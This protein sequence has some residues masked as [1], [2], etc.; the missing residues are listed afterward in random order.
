MKCLIRS[1][2]CIILG[3]NT[4]G[5]T[6]DDRDSNDGDLDSTHENDDLR[7]S[8]HDE[9][10]DAFKFLPAEISDFESN[11]ESDASESA[12]PTTFCKFTQHSFIRETKRP[13]FTHHN[14]VGWL[15]SSQLDSLTFAPN[16]Q[17]LDS[18]GFGSGIYVRSSE[19]AS[20]N[21]SVSQTD[22]SN[23]TLQSTKSSN[24]DNN[25]APTTRPSSKSEE[26]TEVKRTLNQTVLHPKLLMAARS[27]EIHREEYIRKRQCCPQ[28]FC[29]DSMALQI[30]NC[31]TENGPIS[32]HGYT[33]PKIAYSGAERNCGPRTWLTVGFLQLQHSASLANMAIIHNS[34]QHNL[35]DAALCSAHNYFNRSADR[36]VMTDFEEYLLGLFQQ[37]RNVTDEMSATVME[38]GCHAKYVLRDAVN[39]KVP[40]E[41]RIEI[42]CQPFLQGDELYLPIDK[43]SNTPIDDLAEYF[44]GLGIYNDGPENIEFD[45]SD[46]LQKKFGL[47]QKYQ[48]EN[49]KDV[50]EARIAEQAEPESR[51]QHYYLFFTK[52]EGDEF[53]ISN[54]PTA[55]GIMSVYQ[56]FLSI[57]IYFISPRIIGGVSWSH[58]TSVVQFHDRKTCFLSISKQLLQIRRALKMVKLNLQQTRPPQT[59]EH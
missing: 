7:G 27:H 50:I 33:K 19:V 42:Q 22:T 35:I 54:A 58:C 41:T 17:A 44:R 13:S 49:H 24:E 3:S 4:R 30:G 36:P 20:E 34:M 15:S 37:L 21:V 8:T 31:E 14:A 52:T 25:I 18:G 45:L 57:I 28:V 26:Y 5:S 6:L 53:L 47:L 12:D 2:F 9:Q 43:S 55:K 39:R 48:I 11:D 1:M 56:L 40:E 46:E 29:N 16:A 51:F 23:S 10:N 32:V 38:S 59:Q